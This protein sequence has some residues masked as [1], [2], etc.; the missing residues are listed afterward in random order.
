M[1]A[2]TVTTNDLTRSWFLRHKWLLLRRVS[3]LSI[4]LLFMLG[5]L[6]GIWIIKGSLVS[7]L[8]LET[9]PLTDPYVLLQ[10]MVAGHW[11]ESTALLGA[12]FVLGFYLLVGGR[13]YCAWVC[14][15]N[16]VSD[17]AHWLRRKLGLKGSG[18]LSNETRYWLLAVIF[19]V[20][21]ITGTLVWEL[22][23]PPTLIQRVLFYGGGAAW[24]VIFAVFL[25]ELFISDHGWCGRLCPMGA[26]YSV[27]GFRSLIKVN[28]AKRRSCDN[29]MDCFEVCPEPQVI[30]PAL[31]GEAKNLNSVITS[32]NCTNCGRCIDVCDKEVFRFSTRF[33]TP[34]ISDVPRNSKEIAS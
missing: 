4:L 10:A 21:A 30:N 8:T 11:P 7:S 17:A 16:M 27:L 34:D 6:A 20:T 22:L 14:P 19:I 24:L 12:A 32:S 1:R 18:R 5:P 28:A 2:K 31:K 23:N 29:C 13:V 15:V 3:Q 9:V 26:F 33:G 25:F